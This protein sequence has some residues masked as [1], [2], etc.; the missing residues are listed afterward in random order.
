MFIFK[1]CSLFVHWFFPLRLLLYLYQSCSKSVLLVITVSCVQDI[2]HPIVH[3]L[4]QWPYCVRLNA[5]SV[6]IGITLPGPHTTHRPYCTPLR[7]KFAL[8]SPLSSVF[9]TRDRVAERQQRLCWREWQGEAA[10]LQ[11]WQTV[12]LTRS[13]LRSLAFTLLYTC[14]QCLT[15]LQYHKLWYAKGKDKN[16]V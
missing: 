2:V 5:I 4:W 9:L 13:S 12:A 11:A 14:C 6:V 15:V 8:P 16:R 3:A 10:C 1:L 7:G